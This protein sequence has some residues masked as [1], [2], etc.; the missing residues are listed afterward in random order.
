MRLY[1]MA[2][3]DDKIKL[4]DCYVFFNTKDNYM[5]NVKNKIKLSGDNIS[6]KNIYYSEVSGLYYLYKNSKDKSYGITHYR[7]Y[8]SRFYYNSYIFKKL[9]CKAANRILKKYDIIL[10]KKRF[11]KDSMYDEYQ[12]AAIIDD[13]EI[14]KNVV[15]KID[16]E[17]YKSFIIT[18]NNNYIYHYNMFIT[19]KIIIDEYYNM[20]FRILDQLESELTIQ[21]INL[22]D[23]YQKRVFGFLSER[24][25]TAW[26]IYKKL[27]IKEVKVVKTLKQPN[28]RLKILIPSFFERLIVVSKKIMRSLVTKTFN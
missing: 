15:Y 28:N 21:K 25:F 12:R 22:R 9:S 27:S 13:L 20:L 3:N 5:I 14:T 17:F 4:P 1:V 6:N 8:F 7:R 24:I 23:N 11:F 16:P 19:S 10:P 2:H 26:V 18:L